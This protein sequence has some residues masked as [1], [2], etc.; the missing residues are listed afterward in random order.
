MLILILKEIGHRKFNFVLATIAITT[1][2]A[3]L[4]SFITTSAASRR[5]TIRLT[6]DM[7]FNL[8][9][10]PKQTNM[11]TFW[12]AG[13]SDVTM[14]EDYVLS[15]NQ[16]KDFSYAH[17]AATLNERI[18]W[19][20]K[21]LILTG[22]TLKEIEPS[23]K[24]KSPMI[25][26]IE[27]GTVQLGYEIA[28]WFDISKGDEIDLL[29]K[30]FLVSK[31]LPENGS[32]DDIRIFMQL[33]G[34]QQLLKKEGRINEIKA[35][36]CLCLSD[37]DADPLIALRDQLDQVLPEAKVVMNKTI[38]VARERQRIMFEKYFA[39]IL[40]VVVFVCAAWIGTLAMLNVKDR[41]QEIGVL[42][43]LG[44]GAGKVSILFL[45][46]AVLIGIIG[47]ILG[48]AVGTLLSLQYGPDIFRVTAKAIK[49]I[50]NLLYISLVAAPVFAAISSFIPA[51]IAVT[52]DPA[53][54][55]REE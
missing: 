20:G 6:R 54:T 48:F 47:A 1:A 16:F 44:Y 17:L 21:D 7:G 53:L 22:L 27:P 37:P 26:T 11:D 43:A 23:G 13:F 40:P 24:S 50:Y 8:R 31:V 46:K 33:P 38:A 2:V 4:V 5:E 29:G 3:L 35:L 41:K 45:G 36:N 18:T 52:H 49:P 9:I 34:A 32:D 25:F 39:F 12:A 55:L 30:N 28:R 10:I 14:P 51:M 42:R 19:Q 15:F